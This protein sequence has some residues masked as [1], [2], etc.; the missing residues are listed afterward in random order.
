MS[1]SKKVEVNL[2]LDMDLFSE[3]KLMLVKYAMKG[4]TPQE[5]VK[6]LDGVINMMDS[7][8][9]AQEGDNEERN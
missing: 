5:L 1:R 8:Q 2:Q 6:A 4:E 3:Q 7:I 9:D